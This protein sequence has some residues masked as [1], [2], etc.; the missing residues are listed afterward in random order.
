M[1]YLSK[2]GAANYGLHYECEYVLTERTYTLNYFSKSIAFDPN[3]IFYIW[4]HYSINN[5]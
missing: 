4:Y 1:F 5:N 3:V 2:N